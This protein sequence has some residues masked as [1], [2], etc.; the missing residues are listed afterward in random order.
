MQSS[1]VAISAGACLT[2]GGFQEILSW[3]GL[4]DACLINVKGTLWPLKYQ[5][6]LQAE[7][8]FFIGE[9]LFVSLSLHWGACGLAGQPHG[10]RR[11]GLPPCGPPPLPLAHLAPCA[12]GPP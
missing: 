2:T 7:I 6:G 3:F 9:A 5:L 10:G 4:G 12:R 11:A 1:Y 8:L